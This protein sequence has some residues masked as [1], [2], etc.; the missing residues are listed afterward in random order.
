MKGNG[1]V[2]SIDA[3]PTD[4]S[5]AG[6]V[7]AIQPNRRRSAQGAAA[8]QS[9][10]DTSV[11][12]ERK[13]DVHENALLPPLIGLPGVTSV[14]ESAGYQLETVYFDTDDLV[15]AGCGINVR[16][17]TGGGDP[18]WH[19]K[20]PMGRNKRREIHE[21]LGSD[22]DR[23]PDHLLKFVRV[24]LRDRTIEPVVRLRIER[25]VHRLHGEGN[26]VLAEITDDQ[27]LA[28]NIL[29]EPGKQW[30]EWD[31]ELVDGSGDLL[32]AA[33]SILT[34]AGAR[35]AG[36]A[37][38]LAWALGEGNRQDESVSPRRPR[39]KDPAGNILLAFVHRQVTEL[40]KH[41]PGVRSGEPDSVHLMRVSSRRIRSALA[42]Y[43]TLL[44]PAVADGLRGEL[45][46]LADVL[47]VARDT[48]IIR[49]RLRDLISA[50]PA[51][52]MMGPISQRIDEELGA[53]HHKARADIL[54][55][56]EDERYYRLL[57]GLEKLLSAPPLTS[58][59]SKPARKSAA[60][61]I[62]KDVRRL[63]RAVGTAKAAQE[64]SARDQSLH[65]ARKRAKRLRYAAEAASSVC[66]NRGARLAAAAHGIQKNLGQYQDSVVIRNLL[67]RLG[68]EA[69]LRGENGFSYGRLH[70][71]EQSRAKESEA[72]FLK[73]W[74][75][76]R[77]VPFGN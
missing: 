31:V 26:S 48:E 50:D 57:D 28:E 11:E 73:S 17:R 45:K 59:A 47:G 70:Y 22:P 60:A 53:D 46:W 54:A 63:R 29:Q 35:R 34:G 68:V 72:E 77:K 37:S 30:R 6:Q 24:Y 1:E 61:L 20:L 41:D 23:V 64:G 42:T 15:L 7:S 5:Q 13:Y 65:E 32:N 16:R 51:E 18:G 66:G 38:K 76:F 43:R 2:K 56:L 71:M 33:K 14:E 40:I 52:L 25:T 27:V 10:M 62:R 21:P 12:I 55:A 75:R 19:L 58:S 4:A 9:T 69:H 8:V 49:S 44:D 36:H 39:R 74:K 3:V 67:R